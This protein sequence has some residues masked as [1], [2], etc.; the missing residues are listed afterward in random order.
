MK[1][2]SV[3]PGDSLLDMG[4]GT[5]VVGIYARKL[6]AE[7]VAADVSPI[8]VQHTKANSAKNSI[9]LRILLSDLFEEVEGRF[10]IITFSTPFSRLTL[11]KEEDRR[12]RDHTHLSRARTVKRFISDLPDHLEEDG[13]CFM[14]VSP[15]CPIDEY[16]EVAKEHGLKWEICASRSS[17]SDTAFI[18]RLSVA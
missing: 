4:S 15:E 10:D 1:F 8:A 13:A 3:E 12:M 18:V 6:G 14:A 5:G 9:S 2:V 16:E 17:G 11:S 7:V